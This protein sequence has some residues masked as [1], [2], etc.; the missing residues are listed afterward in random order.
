MSTF[1]SY[2]FGEPVS[3]PIRV[4]GTEAQLREFADGWRA[5][6]ER[7]RDRMRMHTE[8]QI[9]LSAGEP[10]PHPEFEEEQRAARARAEEERHRWESADIVERLEDWEAHD[11]SPPVQD[12]IDEIVRLRARVAELELARHIRKAFV[13]HVLNQRDDTGEEVAS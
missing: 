8:N 5:A 11:Y 12:A 4:H 10:L 7:E 2:E 6:S 1:D 13:E 3:I 9:A